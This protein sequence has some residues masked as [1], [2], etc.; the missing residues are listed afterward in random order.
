MRSTILATVLAAAI[1]SSACSS[2]YHSLMGTEE[3]ELLV[4]SVENAQETQTDAQEQFQTTF[5]AF[6]ELTNFDGGDLEKM[7]DTLSDEY[8][9]AE[10]AAK[11]VSKRIDDVED[12]SKDMFKEWEKEIEEYT[13]ADLRRQSEESLRDTRARCDSLVA[14]MR[15][16]ETSMDPVLAAFKDQVL[17]LKHNL[18]AQAVANLKQ[19]SLEIGED[20]GSLIESM[21]KSIAEAEAFINEF[22]GTAPSA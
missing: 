8:D 11:K 14:S 9:D 7:Y 16:A 21:E 10:S 19:T 3:R 1:G 4:S 22:Q 6:Q 18:N 13:N 15:E 12:I 5:E 2:M 17:F 20:V